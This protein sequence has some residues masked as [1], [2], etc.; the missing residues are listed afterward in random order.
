MKIVISSDHAGFTYK[1]ILIKDIIAQ[2]YDVTDL[3]TYDTAPTDYPDHAADVAHAILNGDAERGILICG[4]GVGVSV[5]ANKFKGIRA[6][7]CHDT[8]SAH[9]SV[10]HDDANVLCI[11]ERIV[12]IELA[13]EIVFSFLKAV[14]SQESRHERRLAKI[15]AIENNNMK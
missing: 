6:G 7:V 12:G 3:G 14:F 5:A 4:S 9:Q 11:G 15:K 8:Y 13:R 1:N 10:E 2:G